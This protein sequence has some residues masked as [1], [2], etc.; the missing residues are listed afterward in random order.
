MG[1]YWNFLVN[2]CLLQ[3]RQIDESIIFVLFVYCTAEN[4]LV[5][6][7]FPNEELHQRAKNLLKQSRTLAKISNSTSWVLYRLNYGSELRYIISIIHFFSEGLLLSKVIQWQIPSN[8]VDISFKAIAIQLLNANS[9]N[10]KNLF[11]NFNSE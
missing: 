3:L 1:T 2:G 5:L 11:W 8:F 9:M 4:T 10:K 6:Y 7:Q